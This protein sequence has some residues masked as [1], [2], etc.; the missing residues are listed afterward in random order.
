M[1]IFLSSEGPSVL[2]GLLTTSSGW[3]RLVHGK[4]PSEARKGRSH[5]E[6]IAILDLCWTRDQTSMVLPHSPLLPLS[7][8][9]PSL[10]SPP[11]SYLLVVVFMC[12]SIQ[13]WQ[14]TH[15]EHGLAQK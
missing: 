15:T 9:S 12:E 3:T 14:V 5:T 7:L 10:L 6:G 11:F 1:C 13:I 2:P 8:I 4:G